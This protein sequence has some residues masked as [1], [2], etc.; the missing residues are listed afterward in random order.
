MVDTCYDEAIAEALLATP[1]VIVFIL[2][3]GAYV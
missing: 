3:A 2:L 1:G